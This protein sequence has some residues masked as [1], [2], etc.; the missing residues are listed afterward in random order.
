MKLTEGDIS[1]ENVGEL[2]DV[3]K[4]GV[5]KHSYLNPINLYLRKSFLGWKIKILKI[6]DQGYIAFIN[7]RSFFNTFLFPGI[8]NNLDL[9]DKLYLIVK[10]KKFS[11]MYI[12]NIIHFYIDSQKVL[13]VYN[14]IFNGLSRESFIDVIYDN[15]VKRNKQTR[16]RI[17]INLK[18]AK[19]KNVRI[20]LLQQLNADLFKEWY[21]NCYLYTYDNKPPFPYSKLYSYT[22]GL[23]RNNLQKFIIA[24]VDDKVV[25]GIAILMDEYSNI[26]WYNLGAICKEGRES[27]AGY[28][29]TDTAIKL[30]SEQNKILELYG[31][32]VSDHDPKHENI[33]NFKKVF[34]REIEIPYFSYINPLLNSIIKL[35]RKI[36]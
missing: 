32:S 23:L 19:E 28:L 10:N 7:Q 15:N 2:H 12:S 21:N 31:K 36:R 27:G 5:V 35:I 3:Y 33:F 20:Y 11:Y 4:Q 29:L 14:Q 30:V 24:K 13:N 26:A 34:G 8:F 17:N 18:K 6:R 22:E 1:E 25:G 9:Y 16:H